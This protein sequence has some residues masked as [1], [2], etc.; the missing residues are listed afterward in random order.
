MT[1]LNDL[2]FIEIMNKPKK[3]KP[4]YF[5]HV[6]FKLEYMFHQIY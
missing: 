1:Y 2:I 4:K 3:I 6:S 5:K